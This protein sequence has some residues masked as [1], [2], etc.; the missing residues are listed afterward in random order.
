[1]MLT[2]KFRNTRDLSF[3]QMVTGILDSYIDDDQLTV[4]GL[5]TEAEVELACNAFE[6][7]ILETELVHF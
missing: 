6:A 7:E 1:M 2:L 4:R 5:M 3:F